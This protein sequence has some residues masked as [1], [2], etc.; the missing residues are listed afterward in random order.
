MERIGTLKV[1]F[2][3]LNTIV[4]LLGIISNNFR[5]INIVGLKLEI[6]GF[7]STFDIDTYLLTT[8]TIFKYV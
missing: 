6:S 4:I 7:Y 2:F 8:L 1:F 5:N 3:F